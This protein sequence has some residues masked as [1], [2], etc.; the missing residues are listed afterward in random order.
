MLTLLVGGSASGDVCVESLLIYHSQSPRPIRDI[1][2]SF[3]RQAGRLGSPVIFLAK[4]SLT[5]SVL[6]YCL[7]TGTRKLCPSST[8]CQPGL[9][10]GAAHLHPCGDPVYATQHNITNPAYGSWGDCQLQGLPSPPH[11]LTA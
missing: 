2:K 9:L 5:I 1:S 8:M 11:I 10:G 6:P 3:G 7:R 4:D